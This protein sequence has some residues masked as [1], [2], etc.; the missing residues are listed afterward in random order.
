MR[1]TAKSVLTVFILGTLCVAL[2]GP[3]ISLSAHGFAHASLATGCAGKI[4]LLPSKKSQPSG[5]VCTSD[6]LFNV[7]SGGFVP[8]Q[9]HEFSKVT[10]QVGLWTV[11]GEDPDA[12]ASFKYS[13]YIRSLTY[14]LQKVPIHLFNSVLTV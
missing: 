6:Q 5:V 10:Q 14:P 12:I 1:F 4:P 9:A 13:F 11:P 7:L 3:G 8:P 2:S